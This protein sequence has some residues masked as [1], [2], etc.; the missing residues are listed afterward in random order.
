MKLSM[1]AELAVRGIVVLASRH[2]Q[3]PTPLDEICRLRKLPRDYM[4]RIFSLLSRAHLVTAIRGKGGGYRLAR[5]PKQITL[6]EVIEAVEGQLAVN[7]CQHN[8]PKCEE[9]DCRVRPVW[10]DLQ[11]KVRSALASKTLDEL[12]CDVP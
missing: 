6:L 10:A 5:A 4:T 1:A 3:K 2:G 7:L 11:K 8:P 12:I 9:E